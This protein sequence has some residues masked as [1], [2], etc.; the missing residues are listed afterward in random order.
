MKRFHVHVAVAD[1]QES[2]KFY[3]TF[4]NSK[5]SVERGLCEMDA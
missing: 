2:I 5:P 4:F 3:S 1:V